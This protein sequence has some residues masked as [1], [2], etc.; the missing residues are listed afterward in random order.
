M[1]FLFASM[2]VLAFTTIRARKTADKVPIFR[3][4]ATLRQLAYAGVK[5]LLM[6]CERQ[7]DHGA[8]S[9]SYLRN[10]LTISRLFSRSIL[11]PVHRASSNQ[12]AHFSRRGARREHR[13]RTDS[14]KQLWNGQPRVTGRLP[15]KSAVALRCTVASQGLLRALVDAC[16]ASTSHLG[17]MGAV[18][19]QLLRLGWRRSSWPSG[20]RSGLLA[21]NRR[22]SAE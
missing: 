3:W 8:W 6:H 21:L 16:L 5:C 14:R 15:V 11:V 20:P 9:Q 12:P 7:Q 19:G 13:Q 10:P 1:S 4:H 22:Q 18:G 2:K 17:D